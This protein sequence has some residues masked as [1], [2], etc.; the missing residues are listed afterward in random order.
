MARLTCRM[1]TAG[2]GRGKRSPRTVATADFVARAE[3]AV[4]YNLSNRGGLCH[5][6][7]AIAGCHQFV[8]Q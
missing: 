5:T 4:S 2:N 1:R 8:A 7:V 3:T 6:A